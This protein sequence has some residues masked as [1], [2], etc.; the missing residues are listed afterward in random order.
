M[1][2]ALLS[3]STKFRKV[4]FGFFNLRSANRSAS[5]ILALHLLLLPAPV[6][7]VAL[8]DAIKDSGAAAV[9]MRDRF[10]SW[11]KASPPQV[12]DARGVKSPPPEQ[13]ID[14]LN[15]LSRL[16]ISPRGAVQLQSRERILFTAIP[17]DSEGSAIHGLQAEWDSSDRQVLFVKRDGQAV[18]GKPGTAI[19]LCPPC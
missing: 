6:S 9:G 1:L 7:A 3:I 12:P 8:R 10:V 13:T 2:S 19:G 4:V 14:K 17:F 16:Q 5:L 15:R 11:V 18:A